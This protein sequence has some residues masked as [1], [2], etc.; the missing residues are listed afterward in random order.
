MKTKQVLKF[1]K[2]NE[3]KISIAF[4]ALIILIALLVG[5]NFFNKRGQTLP[6][7]T[8]QNQTQASPTPKEGQVPQNLPSTYKVQKGDNLWKI[9]EQVYGSGYNWTD[10]ARANKLANPGII[11]EGQELAMPQTATR[12]LTIQISPVPS[13]TSTTPS[14]TVTPTPKILPQPQAIP[15]ESYTV[16]RGD[17]LWKIAVRAY[18]DGFQWVKIWRANKTVIANHPDLIYPN[19]T[20]VIPR[21]DTK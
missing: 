16:V 7:A 4:G 19:Q 11:S 8:A 2:L 9:S 3:S 15:G 20:F 10:I 18:G 12:Q 5:F 17:S 13:P 14:F 6:P 21:P 1:V